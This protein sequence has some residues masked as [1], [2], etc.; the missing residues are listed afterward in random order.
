MVGGRTDK[1]ANSHA[2]TEPITDNIILDPDH[3]KTPLYL[4]LLQCMLLQHSTTKPLSYKLYN[5][6]VSKHLIENAYLG[7]SACLLS[8]MACLSGVGAADIHAY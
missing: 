7:H 5:C 1:H 2:H 6:Q 8:C 4:V 3:T